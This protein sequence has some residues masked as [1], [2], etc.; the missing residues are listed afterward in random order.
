MVTTHK[1]ATNNDLMAASPGVNNICLPKK[2]I[3][4]DSIPVLMTGKINYPAVI[5]L[6]N[7]CS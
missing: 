7:N 1:G 2:I 5:E 3:V 4:V 6:A